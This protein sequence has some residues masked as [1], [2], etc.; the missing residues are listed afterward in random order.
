MIPRRWP[1]PKRATLKPKLDTQSDSDH[2][3]IAT[4]TPITTATTTATGTMSHANTKTTT[5]L[6][7][8]NID[9]SQKMDRFGIQ[10]SRR[11]SKSDKNMP[12][13]VAFHP[14]IFDK[15]AASKRRSEPT[16]VMEQQR[17]QRRFIDRIRIDV[18]GGVGGNGCASF[19]ITPKKKR[20]ADG[21]N[22]GRGGN[23]KLVADDS[24]RI[25][26]FAKYHFTAGNGSNG[27]S[28]LKAGKN[29][30]DI[31][32]AVPVG[33][34]VNL[35]VGRDPETHQRILEPMHDLDT[36]GKQVVIARG[37]S[38][39][40]GNRS[41]RTSHRRMSRVS[42]KGQPGETL[43]LELE[44]R[45]IADVG[46]VGFPNAGKSSL[47]RS[48]SSANPVIANYA[49]TTLAPV[50]GMAECKDIARTQLKFADLPGLVKGAH[51][52]VGLGF[53]FLRHIE[54]TKMILYV[55]DIAGSEG[56]DPVSDLL[57][58]QQELG[59]YNDAL[60]QLPA[61]I[62]ANK[63]DY[64]P[65]IA[66]ENLTRLR[67]NTALPVLHG[68]VLQ[69]ENIDQVVEMCRSQMA[70]LNA[71]IDSDAKEAANYRLSDI[72]SDY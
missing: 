36:H 66:Q 51:R 8:K 24:V 12:N 26:R 53:E 28:R 25:L 69:G 62:F 50:V 45:T 33:T 19:E 38:G 6:D 56:R 13:V 54:R 61:V 64:D 23:V 37:G 15:N 39:G 58:L 10:D 59:L 72:E 16:F 57:Q 60:L 31:E 9:S 2:S 17:Q 42:S 29:G 22:G 40:L 63:M 65:E 67:Q 14:S 11:A 3:N 20:I 49:F 48:I 18:R 4:P 52:N 30:Q 68:S 34:V 7:G 47:L 70:K 46:L 43:A 41:Y 27:G 44:L 1:P 71:Q 35:V 55:V 5:D 32:L 21:A